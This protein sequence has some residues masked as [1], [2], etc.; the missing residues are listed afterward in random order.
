LTRVLRDDEDSV[1]QLYGSTGTPMA[2]LVGA[3]GLV[4]G[5]LVV[6]ATAIGALVSTVVGHSYEEVLL[7]V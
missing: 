2:L 7:G 1:A 5:E 6:G 4:A 3:D